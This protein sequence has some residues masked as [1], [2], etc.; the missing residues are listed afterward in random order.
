[1]ASNNYYITAG[2]PIA[3][4]S[5]QSPD[6]GVNTY[7]IT[8]GLPKEKSESSPPTTYS[9]IFCSAMINDT[10]FQSYHIKG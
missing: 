8:A 5:D 10:G 4:A 2:L 1:M 9:S 6:A 7:Y 3:K